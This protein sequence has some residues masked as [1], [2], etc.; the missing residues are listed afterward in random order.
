ML[1]DKPQAFLMP[2]FHYNIAL[3]LYQQGMIKKAKYFFTQA[4]LWQTVP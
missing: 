4:Q 2:S 1:A 3:A